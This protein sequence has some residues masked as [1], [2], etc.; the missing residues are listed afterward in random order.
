MMNMRSWLINTLR[1]MSSVTELVPVSKIVSSSAIGVAGLVQPEPPFIVVRGQVMTPASFPSV[2][3]QQRFLIWVHDRP[4]SWKLIESTLSEIR[5]NLE[6]QPQNRGTDWVCT[7]KWESDSDDLPDDM[8][9]TITR[10]GSYLLTS[11]E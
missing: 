1:N 6:S 8:L 4:G 5:K 10:Y 9:G 3:R 7:A 2:A 11:R